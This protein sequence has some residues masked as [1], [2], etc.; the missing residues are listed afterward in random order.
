MASSGS[1]PRP[2][3]Q[4]LPWASASGSK[5]EIAK[6]RT[7]SV[8]Y[9]KHPGTAALPRTFVGRWLRAAML[10]QRDERDRLVATLNRGVAGWNDDEPAVVEAAAELVL[11]RYFGPGQPDPELA[12]SL[13]YAVTAGLGQIRRPLDERHADA[14][15]HSALGEPSPVFD[16]L[17]PG[18]KHVLKGTA[19]SIAAVM[20]DLDEAAV[21]EL[22]REAERVAFERGWHPPLA[23]RGKF[24][25]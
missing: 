7:D 2:W 8:S 10:D 15:I 5:L 21:D 18:D 6:R 13:A 22:L 9:H 23:S 1:E 19:T 17:K 25:P 3:H 4:R 16:A 14:V 20:M 11:R 24:A 12:R